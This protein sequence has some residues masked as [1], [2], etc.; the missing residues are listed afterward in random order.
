MTWLDR[1]SPA[2]VD[3]PELLVRANNDGDLVCDLIRI[4][5]VEFPP[6]LRLLQESVTPED[7]KSVER[8]SRALVG[9]LSC[10]SATRAVELGQEPGR[11]SFRLIAYLLERVRTRS[12]LDSASM[13]SSGWCTHAPD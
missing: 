8:N 11:T 5:K 3:I 6:L 9:M 12:Y 4:V 13:S 1:S 2:A 7:T 10:L